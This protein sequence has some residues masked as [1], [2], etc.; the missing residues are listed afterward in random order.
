M[1]VDA[2][3]AKTQV[4]QSDWSQAIEKYRRPNVRK[5]I[6]QLFDT[7]IPYFAL[8]VLMVYTVQHGYS[9]W[10]TVALTVVAGALLVRIFILFHD[11][12][13]GSFFTSR[14]A[15]KILGYV[16]GIL[17]FTPYEDWRRSHIVHH[18]TAGNLDRRGVG[19]VW[20]LTVEEYLTSPKRR[21]LLY[22]LCR[23]PFVMF[24]LGPAAV[25]L[26]AQRFS[27][28]GAGKRERY[29][30]IFTN[31]MIGGIIGV[32]C[33]TIGIRT[34]LL[35]QLPIILIAG[36][37]GMWLFYI[38][39]QTGDAY[40]ARNEEWD[41]M[42]AALVGSSHYQLPK[43]LQWFTGNIGLHHVHHLRPRIPNYNLQQCYDD[44]PALQA[45]E[46]LTPRKSLKSLWM[47]LWDEKQQKLVSFRSLRVKTRQGKFQ[48]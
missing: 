42:K 47:N 15:N 37:I 14:R 35:T 24:G 27:Q 22:R 32:G 46:P 34:Y 18:T 45:V 10:I 30:V 33:L 31:L 4:T 1:H 16:C 43:V 8:W 29:S 26:I 13:H 21:R 39:H 3:T 44:I 19:D 23:N 38:Q 48:N 40:W 28:K 6:W 17:T 41:A 36:A 9:Y 11:C 2:D 20:T 7:F 25:L 5:A 12:T